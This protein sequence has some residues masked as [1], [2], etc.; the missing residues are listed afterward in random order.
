M[1][2]QFLGQNAMKKAP[3]TAYSRDVAPS[4]FDLFGD[5][6]QVSAGQ[7]FSDGEALL[8]AINPMLGGIEKMTF[9]SL[10]LEWMERLCRCIDTN[11][12]CV[13]SAISSRQ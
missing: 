8:G 6:K 5:L 4:D 7:E 1:M 11:G 12:E 3:H 13:D 9:E 10:F 2:R